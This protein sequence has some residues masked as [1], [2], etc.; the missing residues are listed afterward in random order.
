MSIVPLHHISE[1]RSVS[2]GMPVIGRWV[3]Y[4]I[5]VY[6]VVDVSEEELAFFD[7]LVFGEDQDGNDTE[8]G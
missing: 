3:V 7:V 1:K 4:C 6:F 8:E 2:I 5:G